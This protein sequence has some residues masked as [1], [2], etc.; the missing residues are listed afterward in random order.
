MKKAAI[1]IVG[2]LMVALAGCN[3]EPESD[4]PNY[5]VMPSNLSGYDG[6]GRISIN[7]DLTLQAEG[8]ERV[9]DGGKISGV[10][11]SAPGGNVV[12]VNAT[13]G[14]PRIYKESSIVPRESRSNGVLRV[15]NTIQVGSYPMGI[16]MNPNPRGEIADLA[17]SLPGP[18]HYITRQ[19]SLTIE[20]STLIKTEGEYS[21]YR[22][23]GSFDAN[24]HTEDLGTTNIDPHVTGNFDVLAVSN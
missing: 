18:T 7:G 21:L 22:I 17:L 3:K 6:S 2:L 10:L 4:L 12:I 5:L 19:G 15:Y 23:Q 1:W 8:L 9:Q 24:L 20:S 14:Q 13:F 16:D 11:A